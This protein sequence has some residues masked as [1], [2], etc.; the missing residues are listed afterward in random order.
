MKDLQ[1]GKTTSASFTANCEGHYTIT[2]EFQSGRTL[3]KETGYVTTGVGF[4]D[5][6][7]VD[8]QAIELASR[9]QVR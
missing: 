9:R 8:D 4:E 3:R 7:S 1:P 2:V 6:I 5:T